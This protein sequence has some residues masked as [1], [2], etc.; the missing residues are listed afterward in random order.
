MM[1]FLR[2]FFMFLKIALFNFGGGYA[3]FP[4]ISSELEKFQWL[5]YAEFSNIIAVSQITPGAIAINTSTF[6]GYE[7][8]SFGGAI[9]STLAIPIPSLVIIIL[10][11][12][13]LERNKNHPVIQ[14]VFYGL[15]PVVAGLITAAIYFVGATV[16]VN[17]DFEG[18]PL[19]DILTNAMSAFNFVSIAIV[20][21]GFILVLKT[22]IPP[23]LLLIIAGIVGIF[24]F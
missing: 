24:V 8:A 7:V 11:Y 15:R 23:M 14:M 2:L 9:V 13:I 4:L 10:L 22:K 18:K 17:N 12:P 6:V 5:T 19:I 20:I 21:V 3:M 16:V 1:I